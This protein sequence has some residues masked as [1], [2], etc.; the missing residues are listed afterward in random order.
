VEDPSGA[1]EEAEGRGEELRRRPVSGRFGGEGEVRCAKP[2]TFV[3]WPYDGGSARPPGSRVLL[4]A[5]IGYGVLAGVTMATFGTV[6]AAAETGA[7]LVGWFR[8][9]PNSIRLGVWA[10]TVALLLSEILV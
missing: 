6:P 4:G 9:Y 7:D 5:T 3:N 1:R 8:A 10:F 2:C